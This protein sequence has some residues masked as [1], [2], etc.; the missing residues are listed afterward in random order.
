MDWLTALADAEPWTRAMIVVASGVYAGAML[1]CGAVLFGLTFRASPEPIRQAT[2]RMLGVAAWFGI[3][4]LLLQWLLQA[5]YLGGGNLASAM[6]PMLLGIVFE[7]APGQRL[8]MAVVGLILLQTILLLGRRFPVL[9]NS[10]A[11]LGVALT[12]AAF[13]QV[14][15]TTGEPRLV[16]SLLLGLHLLAATF[17]IGALWPLYRL[18]GLPDMRQQAADTLARFGRIAAWAVAALLLA[19]VVLAAILL[20]GLRPLLTSAY[21]QFLLAKVLTV[22]GLLLLAATNKW[23]LVPAFERGEASAPHRLRSSIV[24]EMALFAAILLTTA[25]LTT[26]TSPSGG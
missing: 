25:A 16:L 7:G 5:G 2:R 24:L 1:A 8:L 11:L 13:T 9:A 12:L 20:D 23:R 21:G 26:L 14:G 6:D 17:W 10:I 15:H 18:A 3:A 4:M 22:C 19:G